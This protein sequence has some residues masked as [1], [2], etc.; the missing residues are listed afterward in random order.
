MG[1][2]VRRISRV[3]FGS[4][5]VIQ[6]VQ[7]QPQPEPKAD[8]AKEM[9]QTKSKLMGSGYGGKTILTS[10]DGA[11]DEANVQKTVLGG[12]RKRKINA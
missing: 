11:E 10:A 12:G 4:P 7:P 6:P 1:G 5:Q 9:A 2:I 8:S 3:I